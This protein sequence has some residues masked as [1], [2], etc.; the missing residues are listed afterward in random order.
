MQHDI[1]KLCADSLR[2]YAQD[3]RIQL[4]SSHAHEIVAAFFGYKS[5]IA[6]LADKEYPITD[7]KQ[8]DI[9]ILPPYNDAVNPIFRQRKND[10]QIYTFDEYDVRN[11]VS[12][13]LKNAPM[14]SQRLGDIACVVARG[15]LVERFKVLGL[16]PDQL[17]LIAEVTDSKIS[18]SEVSFTVSID[19]IS[20]KG[21]KTQRDSTMIVT[22]SRIAGQVG[23][24]N[25]NVHETRYSGD[26]RNLPNQDKLQPQW[27]YPAGTLVMIRS[28]REIGIVLKTEEGGFYGGGVT[29]CTDT[30]LEAS[31]V[32]EEVFPLTNQ[33]IDFVPLRLFLPYGKWTCLDGSEVLYN[34]DYRALWKKQSDGTVIPM[35]STA[36]IEHDWVKTEYYFN[37]EGMP[38]WN[39][40]DKAHEIGMK[41]LKTWGVEN[42]RPQILDLLP[43]AI[44]NGNADI[45]RQKF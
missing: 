1:I 3:R 2:A 43:V 28:S 24:K 11:I 10:L 39:D 16:D 27:P 14:Y 42:K 32:K 35:D 22:F 26:F 12:D 7:I 29:V 33:S 36:Y 9:I 17:N 21:I 5:K 37:R 25:P 8:A 30:S 6:L 13:V 15:R 40:I 34:R 20:D 38:D 4:K 45:L 41:I 18:A 31:L 19:Y 44:Q 23:F